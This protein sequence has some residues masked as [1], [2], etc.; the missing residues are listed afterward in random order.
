MDP[1]AMMEAE[2]RMAPHPQLP[3]GVGLDDAARFEAFHAGPNREALSQASAMAAGEGEATVYLY[4]PAASGRSHLLQAA[5]ADGCERGLRAGYLP[6]MDPTCSDPRVL[7]GWDA[8]DLVCLDD[9]QAVVAD[10]DWERALFILI[11]GLRASG[12]R[13][14]AA[15]DAPPRNL[16]L[17]LPDLA[18]RLGWGPV[19]RLQ[20]M[21]D[22]DRVDAVLLRGRRRGMDL[23]EDAARYLV[24]RYP[25]SMAD[26]YA[27][28]ERLDDASLAAK[29]RITVPFIREV[30]GKR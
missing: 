9:L 15:A 11:E 10:A 6:L 30:L 22:Q 26:L 7:E 2:R 4:G 17:A 18:T 16:G 21:D 8:L 14:L 27:A 29:R 23:P 28:L 12:G 3:L 19:L 24:T 13:L 5:C 20:A 1:A 25:R